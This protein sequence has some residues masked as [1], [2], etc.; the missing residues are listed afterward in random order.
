M[1]LANWRN[2]S[3]E[4]RQFLKGAVLLEL[5][6]AF[7]WAL[8]NLYVRSIGYSESEAGTLLS[9]AALGVVVT[10]IPAASLY[11]RLGARRSLTMAAIGASVAL[12]GLACSESF[13]WL[14]VFAVLQ[15]SSFT[16]HRVIA[17]P[18]IV[19]AS[20]VGQRT[21]LFGAEFATHTIASTF[22]LAAAGWLAGNL[23]QASIPETDALRWALILGGLC[24]GFSVLCYRRL[25]DEPGRDST[26]D[27]QAGDGQQPG[28]SRGT[29][30]ILAPRH[31]HLWWKLSLPHLVVGLGAGLTIPF[32][33]YYFTDRFDLPKQYL[34]LV[35]AASQVTMTFGV[36]ATPALVKRI[37]LVK[38]T[39]LTEALSLP[40]FLILAV[41]ASFPIAVVAFVMRAALMN[42]SHPLW[43]NLMMEITPDQW[44]AAVNGVSMLAWNLG[45]AMSNHWGGELIER[46]AGWIGDFDGFALP[47]FI[48]LTL[49]VLAIALEAFFFWDKRHIGTAAHAA[50]AV[51]ET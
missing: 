5:G 18:F 48:T 23:Q 26:Q 27:S 25:P 3:P 17:A 22:G 43:R 24:S 30:A 38:A 41:T 40:F 2:F 7:L 37:G 45:W 12:V 32:I 29:F 20:K 33:N 15:G 6:H 51:H 50:Q 11:D 36:L 9:A 16:L 1:L 4:A 35:M 42:L 21:Q 34:G 31:W 14:M 46:S 49:Y 47:M 44:R 19:K 10:T 13:P 8:Q 28:K 39:L